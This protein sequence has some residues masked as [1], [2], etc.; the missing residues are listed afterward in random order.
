MQVLIELSQ[1]CEIEL[2]DHCICEFLLVKDVSEYDKT[3]CVKLYMTRNEAQPY[4]TPLIS[5][6]QLQSK[7][8]YF[9]PNFCALDTTTDSNIWRC[10]V[11]LSE[12]V[13]CYLIGRH[14]KETHSKVTMCS[15]W[16]SKG[17]LHLSLPLLCQQKLK[18]LR[19][20]VPS[21]K[22]FIWYAYE[23]KK[24]EKRPSSPQNARVVSSPR[25]IFCLCNCAQMFFWIFGVGT[26]YDQSQTPVQSLSC[27]I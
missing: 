17:F 23:L 4:P 20:A 25:R 18:Y 12:V 11:F 14:W 16:I 1:I 10:K 13:T 3:L 2:V 15:V 21:A 5:E 19:N 7:G 9:L 27:H 26:S 22:G 24:G 8:D 6:E